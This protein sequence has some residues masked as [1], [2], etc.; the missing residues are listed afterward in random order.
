MLYDEQFIKVYKKHMEGIHGTDFSLFYDGENHKVHVLDL[1]Q[2]SG[3]SILDAVDA[4][5]F[6]RIDDFLNGEF[7]AG[8]S[9][10]EY[11][12]YLYPADG[13]IMEYNIDT[14]ERVPIHPSSDHLHLPFV[15]ICARR[16]SDEY[17]ELIEK[18]E[19]RPV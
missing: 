10:D 3:R 6:R 11:D 19:V 14:G 5:F 13:I 16:W 1:D 2:P 9:R 4:S 12:I 15:A 17:K 7:H 8:A 18:G